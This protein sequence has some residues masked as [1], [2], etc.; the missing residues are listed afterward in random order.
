MASALQAGQLEQAEQAAAPPTAT[1]PCPRCEGLNRL[2]LN[3]GAL[4][5]VCGRCGETIDASQPIPVRARYLDT[6]LAETTATVAALAATK[7][8]P[9]SMLQG[10]AGPAL[11]ASMGQ[12]VMITVDGEAEPSVRETL[13]LTALPGIAFFRAGQRLGAF[14]VPAGLANLASGF[15]QWLG[16]MV[17]GIGLG[18]GV[19]FFDPRGLKD[20]SAKAGEP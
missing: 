3:K 16:P 2:T 1:L 6:V 10:A 11:R 17:A 20:G 7:G 18:Q 14:A 15:A 9:I 12:F 5:G 13:G 8:H 4:R 19:P